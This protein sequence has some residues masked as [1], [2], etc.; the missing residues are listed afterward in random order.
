M[1]AGRHEDISITIEEILKVFLSVGGLLNLINLQFNLP[2]LYWIIPARSN[3]RLVS[4]ICTLDY[5]RMDK[6]ATPSSLY[7]G[8]ERLRQANAILLEYNGNGFAC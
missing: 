7:S 6:I 8:N 3:L 1:T 4:V 5:T 2:L